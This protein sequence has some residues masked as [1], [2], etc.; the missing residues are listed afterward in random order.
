MSDFTFCRFTDYE[1]GKMARLET[2]ES[3]IPLNLFAEPDSDFTIKE[4]EL[5]I[6]NIYGIGSN[7]KVYND[8]ETYKSSGSK[9]ASVSMIPIG[10]FPINP[11]DEDFQESPHIMFTGKVTA[12]EFDS[13]AREDEPNYFVS[14][15]TLEMDA[16]IF[17]LYEGVIKVGEIISGI[18][19]L[20]GDVKKH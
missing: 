11:D 3:E 8:E 20:Y 18:A 7:V 19:W 17:L 16:N 13:D 1:D 9:M 14:V 4:N 12:V 15:K 2:I 10:T 6:V 5:C